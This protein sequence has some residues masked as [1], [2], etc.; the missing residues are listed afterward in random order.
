MKVG[1]Q[2]QKKKIVENKHCFFNITVNRNRY[3]I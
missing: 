1:R 3:S 2:K